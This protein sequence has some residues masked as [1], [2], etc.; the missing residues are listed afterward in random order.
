[1]L[2]G[3][4]F[5]GWY[6]KEL[7]CQSKEQIANQRVSVKKLVGDWEPPPT[8]LPLHSSCPLLILG[9]GRVTG[10]VLKNT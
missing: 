2:R 10:S 8:K 4:T 7:S 1:M 5:H 3:N 6:M 9:R